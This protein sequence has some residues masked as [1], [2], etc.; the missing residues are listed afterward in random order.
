MARLYEIRVNVSE[1][2]KTT[3][4]TRAGDCGL[5]VSEYVR[6]ATMNKQFYTGLQKKIR[7]RAEQ[8][9]R[10]MMEKGAF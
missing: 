2:E 4:R 8:T 1:T 10:A 7:R 5:S 6:Q 3:I 9:A